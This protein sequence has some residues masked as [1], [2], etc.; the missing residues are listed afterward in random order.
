MDPDKSIQI[1]IRNSTNSGYMAPEYAMEG[2]F[3]IKSDVFAFGVL[4]LDIVALV[5]QQFQQ[6]YYGSVNDQRPQLLAETRWPNIVNRV[7]TAVQR[8]HSRQ[9]LFTG[10]AAAFNESRTL[11]LNIWQI[12]IF[13]KVSP[14][15]Q[16]LIHKSCPRAVAARNVLQRHNIYNGYC[17]LNTQYTNLNELQ[18]NYNNERSRDLGLMATVKNTIYASL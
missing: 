1:V 2:L 9:K 11:R 8:I 15:F 16:T 4:L 7:Q 14:S 17:T 6:F 10:E 18:V 12:V 13:Q 3:S 5:H